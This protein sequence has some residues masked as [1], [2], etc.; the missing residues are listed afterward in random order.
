MYHAKEDL[1][2][3]GNPPQAK[4]TWAYV[5]E[6]DRAAMLLVRITVGTINDRARLEQVF[7]EVPLRIDDTDW[8]CVR[9]MDDA[10]NRIIQDGHA[11]TFGVRDWTFIADTAMWYVGLKKKA[12]RFDGKDTTVEFDPLKPATW[13]MFRMMETT[14]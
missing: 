5:N 3:S 2:V 13:D 4:A 7:T 1:I 9:W 10:F 8:N 6:T 12:H 14:S 11:V